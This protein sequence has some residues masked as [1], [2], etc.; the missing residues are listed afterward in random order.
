[1]A[2]YAFCQIEFFSDTNGTRFTLLAHRDQKFFILWSCLAH[3]GILKDHLWTDS[4]NAIYSLK[5]AP[6]RSSFS[7]ARRVCFRELLRT[8]SLI[9]TRGFGGAE[10]RHRIHEK[11]TCKSLFPSTPS[12]SAASTR[13]QILALKLL[14][15]FAF[16]KPLIPPPVLPFLP[17]L[18][19]SGAPTCHWR[20]RHDRGHGLLLWQLPSIFI[21]P[22]RP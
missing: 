15:S 21:L 17:P 5:P 22:W 19:P 16:F 2:A 1:M 18:P 8:T 3:L 9:E 20:C 11:K 10:L 4:R 12:S 13:K 14:H 6:I 7:S